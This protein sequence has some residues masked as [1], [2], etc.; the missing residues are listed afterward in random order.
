MLLKANDVRTREIIQI[1]TLLV[2]E[3]FL[4]FSINKGECK[5]EEDTYYQD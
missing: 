5:E 1:L 3:F 2:N 4:A